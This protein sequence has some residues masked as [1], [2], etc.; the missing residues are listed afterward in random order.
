M[1]TWDGRF[2]LD[3][4]LKRNSKMEGSRGNPIFKHLGLR[5][6][7]KCAKRGD[8][9]KFPLCGIG[10]SLWWASAGHLKKDWLGRG[11]FIHSQK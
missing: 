8:K 11:T 1:R 2:F 4:F 10:T 3:K 6:K 7:G 5:G 9:R